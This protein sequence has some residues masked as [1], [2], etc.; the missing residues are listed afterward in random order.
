MNSSSLPSNISTTWGNG[1]YK[2]TNSTDD[3]TDFETFACYFNHSQILLISVLIIHYIL[4]LFIISIAIY[5][6][7]RYCFPPK[8]LKRSLKMLRSLQIVSILC[9]IM[10]VISDIG[11]ILVSHA[12]YICYELFWIISIN[13]SQISMLFSYLLLLI[14]FII[15]VINAFKDSI[16][17][18]NKCKQITLKIVVIFAVF[19]AIFGIILTLFKIYSIGYICLSISLIIYII[20]SIIV[21]K[22]I[23][24]KLFQFLI[25]IV[26]KIKLLILLL[27]LVTMIILIMVIKV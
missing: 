13:I 20:T 18:V 10:W 16:F 2:N 22:T 4:V 11:W 1:Y 9:T 6:I 26:I 27:I 17:E 24:S 25:F 5:S 3:L 19:I 12:S 14:C 21:V 8:N 15:R 7:R 23:I